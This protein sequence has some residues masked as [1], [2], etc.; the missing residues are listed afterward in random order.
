V[1][2]GILDGLLG[3]AVPDSV[4]WDATTY[5]LTGTG[6]RA[7]DANERAKLGALGAKFPLLR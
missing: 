7:L 2:T 6:R 3:G 4:H 1:I 5:I